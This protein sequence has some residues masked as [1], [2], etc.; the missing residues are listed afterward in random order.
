MKGLML[1]FETM[2]QNVIDCA[3]IDCSMMVFDTEKM[4]SN[5]PYTSKSISDVKKFKLS[6]KDQVDNYGWK[7]YNDTIKFWMSQSDN[8]KKYIKPQSSDLTVKECVNKMHDF[9]ID[10]G[11]MDYWWSR[12]NTFDPI[13]I[14]RLFN[15]QDKYVHMNEYLPYWRVRDI[16]TFIDAKMEFPKKNGFIPVQNIDFWN[17]VFEEHNS[18]WD[19]LADVLRMQAILRAEND[20]EMIER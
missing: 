16:R 17:K 9:M 13:L 15:S 4:L 6:I 1:D 11:K 5:D 10:S 12:S 3:M 19:V 14:W 18:S 8:V 20:L 2:G 7:V